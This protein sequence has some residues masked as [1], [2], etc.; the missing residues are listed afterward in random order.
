MSGGSA[1]G[2]GALFP[3]LRSAAAAEIAKAFASL[4][5]PETASTRGDQAARADVQTRPNAAAAAGSSSWSQTLPSADA[6]AAVPNP[7]RD[8][9]GGLTFASLAPPR[10][11]LASLAGGFSPPT[12][13]EGMHRDHTSAAPEARPSQTP[14]T[15]IPAA[16]AEAILAGPSTD[17]TAPSHRPSTEANATFSPD[18]TGATQK[19]VVIGELAP[20]QPVSGQVAS[21][22]PPSGSPAYGAPVVTTAHLAL[23]VPTPH[24]AEPRQTTLSPAPAHP[25]KQPTPVTAPM[26]DLETGAPFQ[27][28]AASKDQEARPLTP[29]SFPELARPGKAEVTTTITT[30]GHSAAPKTDVA[31]SPLPEPAARKMPQVAFGADTRSPTTVAGDPAMASD[32]SPGSTVENRAQMATTVT[33]AP[34]SAPL[35][36][37]VGLSAALTPALA[38]AVAQ[39]GFPLTTAGQGASA[40]SLVI[41]NAAMIPSWPPAFRLDETGA[42]VAALRAGGAEMAQMSPEE[43]AEYLTKMA[44]AFG[45]LLTVKKRLSKCRKE[46]KEALLGLFSF[47]GVA[48]DT[49][50]KGLQMA[51]D[52]TADQREMLAELALVQGDDGGRPAQRGR[53][54]LRL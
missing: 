23:T 16:L 51:L 52:L 54:R 30:L 4:D 12:M 25:S 2:L 18:K 26:P 42:A 27:E 32:P 28:N 6:L 7:G 47:L 36:A 17:P 48:L 9:A 38:E 34:V 49:L 3:L 20:G 43:A 13:A 10:F 14:M 24:G 37:A 11:V 33:L 22:L 44:A 5:S 21:G 45:F 1:Y 41:F 50:A 31:V 46:E 19:P 15:P 8:G 29:A 40:A 35:P 53:Q 39:G